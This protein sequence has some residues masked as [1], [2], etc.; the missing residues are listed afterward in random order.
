MKKNNKQLEEFSSELSQSTIKLDYLK[1]NI[2]MLFESHFK[3]KYKS[4][5]NEVLDQYISNNHFSN[6]QFYVF[7][8]IISIIILLIVIC[9]IISYHY[10]IDM[11][12][13]SE[14]K[15]IFPMFRAFFVICLY[16]WLLGIN[17]YVW[18][19]A[20]INYKLAFQFTNHYSSVLSICKRAACFSAIFVLFY[21]VYMTLKIKIP[22]FYDILSFIPLDLTP[23]FTWIIL[24]I[25]ILSPFKGFFNY[26]GR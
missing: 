15:S 11:D 5:T 7:I 25:Y 10:N 16:F 22:F 23:L 4:Q 8:G 24:L 19:N 6:F 12:S 26:K 21:I 9:C 18:N 2:A 17:V 20:K 14:F 1:K 3:N 13:D